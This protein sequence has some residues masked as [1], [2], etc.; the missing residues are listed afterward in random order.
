MAKR[1]TTNE[2]IQKAIKVHGNLYDYSQVKYITSHTKI[3]IICTEHGVFEQT[4]DN[5][6]RSKQG[7]PTCGERRRALNRVLTTDEFIHTTTQIHNNFYDYSL[8]KYISAHAK[9]KIICPEHGVFE[10]TPDRHIRSGGCFYCAHENHVGKYNMKLFE[11]NPELKNKDALLYFVKIFNEHETF[12]KVGI[13]VSTVDKRFQALVQ[14]GY[15]YVV[16][17]QIPLPLYDAYLQ[18]QA[19]LREYKEYQYQPLQKFGGWTEC[20]NKQIG[21]SDAY[22]SNK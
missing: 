4:P 11:R 16:E 12:W 10:Q 5:H 6:I 17:R 2:F 8:V 20:F 7:C 22:T 19:L 3:K 15:Q 13:T 18:E 1:L 21:K 9:V 14:H